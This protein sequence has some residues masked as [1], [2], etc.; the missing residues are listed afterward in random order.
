MKF[1][2]TLFAILF[3]CSLILGNYDP[4]NLDSNIMPDK[5]PQQTVTVWECPLCK[6]VEYTTDPRI[7]R[8][9]C[10][11]CHHCSWMIHDRGIEDG[12]EEKE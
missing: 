10:P 8:L 9:H 6:N 5:K 4:M 1:N 2:A 3:C 12:G 7:V 11:G